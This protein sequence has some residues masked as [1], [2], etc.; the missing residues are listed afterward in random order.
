MLKQNTRQIWRCIIHVF[1]HLAINMP[2]TIE[3]IY[4]GN[5]IS[6]INPF[7]AEHYTICG[8][9]GFGTQDMTNHSNINHDLTMLLEFAAS[10]DFFTWKD[11]RD[12]HPDINLDGYASGAPLKDL[13]LIKAGTTEVG[14]DQWRLSVHGLAVY[15]NLMNLNEAQ[16]TS[17]RSEKLAL[18]AIVVAVISSIT[19]IVVA[20]C[21]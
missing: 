8:E 5:Y 12:A 10:H 2:A 11:L 6:M 13:F 21:S 16:R 1:H 9:D 15:L 3:R 17:Q 7:A 14:L 18:V 19:Q 4:C 20:L